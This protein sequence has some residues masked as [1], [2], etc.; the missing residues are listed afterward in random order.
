MH[1]VVFNDCSKRFHAVSALQSLSLTVVEGE[2]LVLLGPNGAGKTTALRL[3]MGLIRPTS[4]T[5]SVFGSPPTETAVHSRIGY[6]PGEMGWPLCVRCGEWLE[7]LANLSGRPDPAYRMQLLQRL[8]FPLDRLNSYIGALSQ[9]MKRKLGLVSAMEHRPALIVLDEPGDGLDPVQQRS[10]ID[11]L[12][13]RPNDTTLVLS[14]HDLR[15]VH[16]LAD[17]IAVF[18]NGSLADVFAKSE[19]D[20]VDALEQRFFKLVGRV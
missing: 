1:P 20:S 4:G 11:L 9:G 13:A 15:E 10:L 17:R 6:L 2:C 16:I 19:V 8:A 3:L 7:F 5:V 14:S 18:A 12:L